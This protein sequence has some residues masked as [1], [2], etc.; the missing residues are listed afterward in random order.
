M[1]CCSCSPRTSNY[2]SGRSCCIKITSTCSAIE[3]DTK[4]LVKDGATPSDDDLRKVL[5]DYA[6]KLK[7]IQAEA[8]NPVQFKEDD[9]LWVG[10]NT[11][12][13]NKDT[14]YLLVTEGSVK[15]LTITIEESLENKGG[16]LVKPGTWTTVADYTNV[17]EGLELV[18]TAKSEAN[19]DKNIYFK[20][21][22]TYTI[23]FDGTNIKLTKVTQ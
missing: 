21:A 17:T 16:R 12:W 10:D 8:A 7:K 11:G 6:D 4:K 13:Q 20:E 15:K 18:D 9:A 5:S 1:F 14:N 3:S 19:D 23:E 2:Y 22:G